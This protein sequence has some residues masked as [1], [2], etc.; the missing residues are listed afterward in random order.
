MLSMLQNK[1]V[2]SLKRNLNKKKGEKT[3]ITRFNKKPL[4]EIKQQHKQHMKT[5]IV[6]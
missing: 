2:Y 4:Q 1:N 3:I 5:C 6:Q